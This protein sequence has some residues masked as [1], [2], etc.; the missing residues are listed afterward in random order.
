[1]KN[2]TSEWNYR[3]PS[4]H[5]SYQAQGPS[6][7][8]ML[9][10][11]V[12]MPA[13]GPHGTYSRAGLGG[14]DYVLFLLW[15]HIQLWVKDEPAGYSYKE[16]FM[17]IFG[18]GTKALCPA[19]SLGIVL[20]DFNSWRCPWLQWR[21]SAY[22]PLSSALRHSPCVDAVVGWCPGAVSDITYLASW[23]VC[24]MDQETEE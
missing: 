4:F 19:L 23:L 22:I 9:E 6:L 13:N 14:W 24:Q 5:N 16:D 21:L 10:C 7:C 11:V 20:C 3:H 15:K 12:N 17:W 18:L 8:W 2:R 1:M